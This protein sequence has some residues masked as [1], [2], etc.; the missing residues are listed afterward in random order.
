M[1][2]A[3]HRV[4]IFPSDISWGSYGVLSQPCPSGPLPR[5]GVLFPL[6]WRVNRGPLNSLGQ[7]QNQAV[8]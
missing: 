8:M 6:H 2:Y 3:S 7:A 1:A 5:E 4:R